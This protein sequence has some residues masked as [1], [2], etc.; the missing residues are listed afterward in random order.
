MDAT[1]Y[2]REVQQLK[3]AL[4]DF[5]A[6]AFPPIADALAEEDHPHASE[7]CDL[8]YIIASEEDWAVVSVACVNFI[9]IL[10]HLS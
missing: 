10:E 3:A 1:K 2:S 5:D 7:L 8:A 4:D 9:L 6:T